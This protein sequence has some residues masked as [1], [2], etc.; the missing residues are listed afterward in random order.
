MTDIAKQAGRGRQIDIQIYRK[1]NRKQ[2]I[3][4]LLPLTSFISIM[5]VRFTCNQYMAIWW[6]CCILKLEDFSEGG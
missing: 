1:K 2:V 6:I 4:T 5:F 3:Y